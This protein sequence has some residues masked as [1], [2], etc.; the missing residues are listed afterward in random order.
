MTR[1][2]AD[3]GGYEEKIHVQIEAVACG[4]ATSGALK[5]GVMTVPC[6]SVSN[7]SKL[8]YFGA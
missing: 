3:N 1:I 5:I 4:L 2:S 7:E 6:F 8:I